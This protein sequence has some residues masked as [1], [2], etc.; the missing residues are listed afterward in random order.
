MTEVNNLETARFVAVVIYYLT[1]IPASWEGICVYAELM[2][3]VKVLC[4]GVIPMNF[5][6]A[7]L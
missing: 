5:S 7:D 3:V 1:H 4:N 6:L 2:H